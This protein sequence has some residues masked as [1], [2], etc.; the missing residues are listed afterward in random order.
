[1]FQS[2]KMTK[3]LGV[4][5]ATLCSAAAAWLHVHEQLVSQPLAGFANNSRLSVVLFDHKLIIGLRHLLGNRGR[6]AKW[7]LIAPE[8]PNVVQHSGCIQGFPRALVTAAQQMSDW[9][10]PLPYSKEVLSA[11]SPQ[12]GVFPVEAGL[13]GLTQGLCIP[14]GR[15]QIFTDWIGRVA[16]KQILALPFNH[17]LH[18]RIVPNPCIVVAALPICIQVEDEPFVVANNLDELDTCLAVDS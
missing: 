2:K 18:G 3:K 6:R 15:D 12:R 9:P 7:I 14:V 5:L 16:S 13:Q 11:D 1:L 4:V 8:D 17:S 10:P